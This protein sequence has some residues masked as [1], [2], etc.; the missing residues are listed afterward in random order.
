MKFCS[1]RTG[2]QSSIFAKLQVTAWSAIIT[3]TRSTNFL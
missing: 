2:T 1:A 3:S